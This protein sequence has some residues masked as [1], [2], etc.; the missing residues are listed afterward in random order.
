MPKTVSR[1]QYHLENLIVRGADYLYFQ[2]DEDQFRIALTRGSEITSSEF[3]LRLDI[4][5]D[6]VP[7]RL[8]ISSWLDTAKGL[9]PMAP[10]QFAML[11]PQIQQSALMLYFGLFVRRLNQ[12]S[13]PTV[14]VLGAATN[15]AIGTLA[16]LLNFVIEQRSGAQARFSLHGGRGVLAPVM[17]LL[18]RLPVTGNDDVLQLAHVL[19][20]SIGSEQFSVR[21]LAALEQ[22]DVITINSRDFKEYG[23][24]RLR[25]TE[26]Q[27]LLG[28]LQGDTIVI[29]EI[30]SEV[31]DDA[32]VGRSVDIE[33]IE[34]KVTFEIGTK[35]LSLE[36][37]RAMKPGSIVKLDRPTDGLVGVF[38][39]GQRIG[40]G[41]LVD[42]DKRMGVRILEMFGRRHG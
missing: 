5:F 3:P 39:N 42:V 25:V 26:T 36:A 40:V 27:F 34:V 20:L 29:D 18:H 12:L 15:R 28:R 24:L 33:N 17:R 16:P 31:N 23:I 13:G 10:E 38:V 37:L 30:G 7:A 41:E 11:P 32:A 6:G 9:S 2:I 14:S 8:F 19:H 4:A 21:A 1:E 35:T 22:G